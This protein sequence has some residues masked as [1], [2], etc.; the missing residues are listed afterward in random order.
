MS[1]CE[2]G[3]MLPSAETQQL[4]DLFR[5]LKL[6]TT[7]CVGSVNVPGFM[8]IL[9]SRARQPES[10][11]YVCTPSRMRMCVKPISRVYSSFACSDNVGIVL[12]TLNMVLIMS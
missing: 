2:I 12:V 8:F 7:S 4:P 5:M 9:V 6:H 10:C 3:N 11:M 1:A